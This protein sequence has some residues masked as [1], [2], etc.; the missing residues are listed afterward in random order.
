[1]S[2]QRDTWLQ[3]QTYKHLHT[4][5]T[6]LELLAKELWMVVIPQVHL[7]QWLGMGKESGGGEVWV[8]QVL[9]LQPPMEAVL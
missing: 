4:G 5:F 1:M 2:R 9:Q 6:L 8:G 3:L 7:V